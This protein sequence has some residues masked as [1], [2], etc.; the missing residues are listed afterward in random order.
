VNH[1]CKLICA[2]LI[3]SVLVLFLIVAP[4]AAMTLE[5]GSANIAQ[6]IGSG[7]SA[8]FGYSGPERWSIDGWTCYP[9][10]LV[11]NVHPL[12]LLTSFLGILFM[13]S[14]RQRAKKSALWIGWIVS[15]YLLFSYFDNKATRFTVLWVPPI[16]VMGVKF[17][18]NC[19]ERKKLAWR[20]VSV[21]MMVLLLIPVANGLNQASQFEPQGYVGLETIVERMTVQTTDGNIV[22][23]G[24]HR[25]P[26]IYFVRKH[27]PARR[28]YVLQGEDIFENSEAVEEI[29]SSYRIRRVY[30]QSAAID[31]SKS[32]AI[33][34]AMSA[35]SEFDLNGRHTFYARGKAIDLIEYGYTGPLNDAMEDIPLKSNL[36]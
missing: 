12:L 5:F 9:K 30:V 6:S 22:Y 24:G 13:F 23:F 25:K 28:V 35:S 15:F 26:F 7:T 19:W 1:R 11:S 14:S 2:P 29:C 32:K 21:T 10:S 36:L 33:L 16:V 31:G 27:D 4:L 20:T 18:S 3:V 8:I 34:A 17:V